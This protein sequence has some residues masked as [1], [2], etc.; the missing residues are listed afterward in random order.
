MPRQRPSRLEETLARTAD[1]ANKGKIILEPRATAAREASDDVRPLRV[2]VSRR[3]GVSTGCAL[4]QFTDLMEAQPGIDLDAYDPWLTT[5]DAEQLALHESRDLARPAHGNMDLL[6]SYLPFHQLTAM[7]LLESEIEQP[8]WGIYLSAGGIETLAREAFV[9][10][11]F[12]DD[13]ALRAAARALY[14]HELFHFLTELAI[15][16]GELAAASVGG[17][18]D[19]YLTHRRA[20]DSYCPMEEGL[21]NRHVL[22]TADNDER[23]ALL[24]WMNSGPPGYRDFARYEDPHAER[25][26]LRELLAHTRGGASR[27]P[28]L[29]E[30]AFDLGTVHL[31]VADVPL[32]FEMTAGSAF[33]AGAWTWGT[34]ARLQAS[35]A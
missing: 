26:A 8:A 21:A 25:D 29:A 32:Q 3:D 6:A 18:G 9:P 4:K 33:A 11:G 34:L 19:Q 12:A 27:V 7:E 24:K 23:A 14:A 20:H 22:R 28:E 35:E 30:L 13:D 16:A 2:S 10:V 15:T 31:G 5:L 17:I 1:Y